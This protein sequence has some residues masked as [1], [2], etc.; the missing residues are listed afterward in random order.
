MINSSFFLSN[1]IISST[2]RLIVLLIMTFKRKKRA[3]NHSFVFIVPKRLYIF[4]SALGSSSWDK[5]IERRD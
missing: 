4:V 3:T 1:V 5:K 2:I